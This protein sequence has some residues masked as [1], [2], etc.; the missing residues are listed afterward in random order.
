MA[1]DSP[2]DDIKALEAVILPLYVACKP[3]AYWASDDSIVVPDIIVTIPEFVAQTTFAPF[4]W[5]EIYP[6]VIV[7]SPP[8]T[9]TAAFTP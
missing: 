3:L 9:K 2:S 6:P 7:T 4:A 8:L 5:A 1:Q